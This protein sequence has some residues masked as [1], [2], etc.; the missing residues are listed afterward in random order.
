MPNVWGT[1]DKL[2][3]QG[4]QPSIV[5][6]NPTPSCRPYNSARHS[7]T[8]EFAG[9]VPVLSRLLGVTVEPHDGLAQI[10]RLE[11]RAVE[12]GKL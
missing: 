3:T 6:S 7:L 4:L 1:T 11:S 9:S 2:V 10:A 12:L 8:N 5:I